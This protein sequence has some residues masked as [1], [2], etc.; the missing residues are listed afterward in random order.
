MKSNV[1]LISVVDAYVSSLPTGIDPVKQIDAVAGLFNQIPSLKSFIADRAI[2]A[3]ERHKALNVAEP[4]LEDMTINTVLLLSKEGMLDRMKRVKELVRR[5]RAEQE[6]K[7]HA[8]V[9]TVIPLN[10]EE[11]E[12]TEKAIERMIGKP[13]YIEN[14]LD[15]N[16]L[17]GL[18]VS[19]GDWVYDASLK[20]RLTRLQNTL[21]V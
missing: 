20:G 12:R 19:I 3:K 1:P 10:Q 18:I 17:A 21:T 14:Q 16:V 9:T 15:P 6:G 11:R 2:D 13:V 7:K 5:L 8:I 4:N